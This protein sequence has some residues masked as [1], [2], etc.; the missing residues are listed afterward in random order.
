MR[1]L[2][3]AV[4]VAVTLGLTGCGNGLSDYPAVAE[5]A[6]KALPSSLKPTSSVSLNGFSF[7]GRNV[8]STSDASSSIQAIFKGSYGKL[9]GGQATGYV[10]SLLEDL[11]SRFTELKSRS[12][13][14]S[15]AT[16]NTYT[17]DLSAIDTS[18]ASTLQLEMDV[19]CYN[20]FTGA[21]D[22]SG[23][24]SGMLFGKKDSNYSMMLLL[25]SKG[26]S[27][28]TF[29][30]AAKVTGKGTDSETVDL[31][32]GESRNEYSRG[33]VARIRSK[34]NTGVYEFVLAS[35]KPSGVN[36]VSGNPV[37][38]GCGLRMI[39]DGTYVYGAGKYKSSGSDCSSPSSYEVCLNASDLSAASPSTACD[40]L[41]TTFTLGDY[42]TLGN[43]DGDDVSGKYTNIYNALQI[44]TDAVKAKASAN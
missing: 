44:D 36:P 16:S 37:A 28:D 38:T 33:L 42:S 15:S 24:G 10:N 32:F 23:T 35:D 6:I 12:F 26:T 2:I 27:G 19:Q 34:T 30:Y 29:G 9:S 25:N 40:T 13:S 3:L 20:L 8:V 22:Q 39:S 1:T 7:P 43:L 5:L 17:V 41:K 11:D 21:G 14:C 31:I 18:L 4:F